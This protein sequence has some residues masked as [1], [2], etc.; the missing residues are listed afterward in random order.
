MHTSRFWNA[1]LLAHTG[2]LLLALAGLGAV[3][4]SVRA[5]ALTPLR[6][7]A[8]FGAQNLPLF[9]G[10]SR[11]IFEKHGLAI[12]LAFTPNSD[13]QRTGLA[14]GAF[15]IAHGAVDNAVAMVES[16]SKDVVIVLGG[17]SSMNEFF[18]VPEI[19]SASQMRGKTLLVDAPNTAY[20]L[21]A[22]KIL[23]ESGVKPG[24]YA[25]KLA[26]ATP[27][28]VKA[29]LS[30]EGE[31]AIVNVPFSILAARQGMRSLGRTSDLLGPYQ[32][33]GAFVMRAWAQAHGD[34]LERYLAAYVEALR[35]ALTPANR[36]ACIALLTARLQVAEDV[37]A[38]TYDLEI[39]PSFGL[40]PDARFDLQGFRNLLS[41]RAELEGQWGGT[42]PAPDR[43]VDL[44]YY[45]RALT[46]LAR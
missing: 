29:L 23:L 20:A 16:A 19:T 42:P 43:F 28:R 38:A 8:F 33:T 7:N 4:G 45:S 2:L 26:G 46:R 21:Q 3:A 30:R 25:L 18:V 24:E 32:G 6:V 9:V 14:E 22:K 41:L 40:T 5:Q 15:E 11:G 13:A 12:E 1:R 31:A 27:S 17:D 34:L 39:D 36:A 10:L 37:A 35:W 44:Q